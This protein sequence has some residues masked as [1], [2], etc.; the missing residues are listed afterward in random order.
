MSFTRLNTTARDTLRN[1]VI[2]LC[3]T[4]LLASCASDRI[5]PKSD[6]KLMG[7]RAGS[8]DHVLM[9][10]GSGIASFTKVFIEEPQVTFN[11]HWLLEFRGDYSERDLERITTSYG[12]MLKKALTDGIAEQTTVTV[13]NSAAEA[14]M[15]FRP[16]LREL[17]IYAPDLSMPG[18][19]KKYVHEIGNA[20]FDL[21]LIQTSN[22]KVVAQFIDHRETSANIGNRLERTDRV[23][24]ARHFRMLMERW[25][26]NLS[27]YLIDTGTLT[28][29]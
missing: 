24:N 15:I 28:G 8:F 7:T 2:L 12:D 26:R 25:T 22:N 11:K 6:P 5:L 19:I 17:N 29:K 13:V 27:S 21:T 10:P 20:T 18:R 9:L 23:T 14:D 16:L 4:L 1:L 3:L